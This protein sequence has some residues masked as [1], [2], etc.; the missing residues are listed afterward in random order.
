MH[1]HSVLWRYLAAMSWVVVAARSLTSDVSPRPS[2]NG[3]HSAAFFASAL[4]TRLAFPHFESR[5]QIAGFAAAAVI[6]EALRLISRDGNP[7]VGRCA[8]RIVGALAGVLI[9]RAF[10]HEENL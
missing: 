9:M 1:L 3:A 5:Y 6:L 10:A 4:V 8:A 2:G 7:S